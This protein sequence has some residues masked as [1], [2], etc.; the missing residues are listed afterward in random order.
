MFFPQNPIDYRF[1]KYWLL[2]AQIL[3]KSFSLFVFLTLMLCLLRS[4]LSRA[5]Y[6]F[7]SGFGVRGSD[8]QYPVILFQSD[9]VYIFLEMC[10]LCSGCWKTLEEQNVFLPGLGKHAT[11]SKKLGVCLWI[12]ARSPKCGIKP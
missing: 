9:R 4:P 5:D 3:T 6:R 11:W 7:F 2:S 12:V 1:G 8:V 10:T